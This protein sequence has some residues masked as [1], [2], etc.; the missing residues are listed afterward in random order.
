MTRLSI[1]ASGALSAVGSGS[2]RAVFVDGVGKGD[3]SSFSMDGIVSCSVITLSILAKVSFR[4]T[5]LSPMML[6]VSLSNWSHIKSTIDDKALKGE[7]DKAFISNFSVFGLVSLI[8]F[9]FICKNSFSFQKKLS[10]ELKVT[11]DSTQ[12]DDEYIHREHVNYQIH[13][14]Y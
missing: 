5:I 10:I 9:S 12:K 8:H 3:G 11:Q 4:T 14:K 13:L 6:F 2:D 7:G 1:D